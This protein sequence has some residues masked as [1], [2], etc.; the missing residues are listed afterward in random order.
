MQIAQLAESIRARGNGVMNKTAADIATKT[1]AEEA[2]YRV[3]LERAEQTLLQYIQRGAI[4]NDV[5]HFLEYRKKLMSG[6]DIE[7]IVGTSQMDLGSLTEEASPEAS[8][9]SGYDNTLSN[10]MANFANK[11]ANSIY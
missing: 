8:K 7:D 4:P 6:K 1:P 9:E 3:L 5:R 2:N 11:R 10:V